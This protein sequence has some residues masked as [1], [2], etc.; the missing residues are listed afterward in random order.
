VPNV[1]LRE[2]K[3][4]WLSKV[5]TIIFC[6]ILAK[7][8]LS[9]D[10]NLISKNWESNVKNSILSMEYQFKNSTENLFHATNRQRNLRANIKNTTFELSPRISN[11]EN[12]KIKYQLKEISKQ[13]VSYSLSNFKS[14]QNQNKLKIANNEI[15]ISYQNNVHGIR[16]DF[17]IQKKINL[18]SPLKVKIEISSPFKILGANDKIVHLKNVL[19]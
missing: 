6:L 8:K 3:L 17:I 4:K 19:L 1:L 13:N 10:Q 16:Q 15:E 7:D 18:N 5:L 12:W 9:L 14:T 11:G 2:K